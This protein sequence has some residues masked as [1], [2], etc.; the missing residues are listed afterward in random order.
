LKLI[1]ICLLGVVFRVTIKLKC[2]CPLLRNIKTSS[3]QRL[4]LSNVKNLFHFC[5]ELK[6][7]LK[8][9]MFCLQVECECPAGRAG[10]LCQL[11][12]QEQVSSSSSYLPRLQ[13]E[14]MQSDQGGPLPTTEKGVIDFDGKS[15]LSIPN[16][17]TKRYFNYL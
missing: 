6:F 14:G 13:E 17:I 15:A 3:E 4:Y 8:P 9:K 2:L 5:E 7:S 10:K 1:E 12:Q 11:Q 16:R